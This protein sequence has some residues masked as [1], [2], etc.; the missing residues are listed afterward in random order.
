MS[1]GA[2]YQRA[3]AHLVRTHSNRPAVIRA[4]EAGA[5]GPR[6]LAYELGF[7]AG[8]DREQL[9]DRSAAVFLLFACLNLTDDLQDGD[10]GAYLD[11]PAREGPA[12]QLLLQCLAFS[13]MAGAGVTPGDLAAVGA[14]LAT[15]A[16]G[17]LDEVASTAWTSARY[18]AV[19]ERIAG[20]QYAVYATLLWSGTDLAVEA[21]DTGLALGFAAHVAEDLRSAD[22]R[23]LSMPQED[24]EE[25]LSV[26]RTHAER[27]SRHRSRAVRRAA[28]SLR[29][30][31]PA[32][33]PAAA[34]G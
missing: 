11:A 18:R 21:R 24:L 10:A 33:G 4:L 12:V 7:D 15:A 34:S 29:L 8:L 13:L 9:L 25:V 17:Q 28:A 27:L 19:G 32:S 3:L 30:E 23:L 6:Q 14:D 31:R 22:P 20:L 26:A 1:G 5:T 2:V 16:T